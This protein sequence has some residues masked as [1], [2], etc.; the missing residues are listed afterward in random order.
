MD[1][2]DFLDQTV[3]LLGGG[4]LDAFQA[5]VSRL[6]IIAKLSDAVLDAF[7]GITE[8]C[9][10]ACGLTLKLRDVLLELG[11]VPLEL[12]DVLLELGDGRQNGLLKLR[13][14]MSELREVLTGLRMLI[15]E[16]HQLP[17]HLGNGF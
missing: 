15:A 10:E 11:D 14:V 13:E 16:L 4:F 12:R 17:M 9:S 2:G 1:H 8:V 7:Q 3:D 6:R 5:G